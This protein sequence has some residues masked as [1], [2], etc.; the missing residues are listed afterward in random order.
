MST[1]IREWS[2]ASHPEAKFIRFERER[3]PAFGS[4]RVVHDNV[5][6]DEHGVTSYT[7]ES[8]GDRVELNSGDTDVVL[9]AIFRQA[10]IVDDLRRLLDAA[11]FLVGD[12]LDDAARRIRKA[13]G[14]ALS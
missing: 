6:A 10:G 7:I 5:T 14:E 4:A 2:I 12:P 8:D 3:V 13:F 1:N 9:A 11:T